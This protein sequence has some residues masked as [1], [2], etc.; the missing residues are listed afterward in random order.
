MERYLP[1]TGM[2]NTTS[3]SCASR[4]PPVT[5]G[6]YLL[7]RFRELV[8][9]MDPRLKDECDTVRR[10]EPELVRPGFRHH[11]RY[12]SK[13]GMAPR[14]AARAGHTAVVTPTYLS[15]QY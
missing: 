11:L 15:F 6:S 2:L 14:T 12:S 13:P 10:Q 4:W 9:G 7:S 8:P 1:G 5:H 3:T